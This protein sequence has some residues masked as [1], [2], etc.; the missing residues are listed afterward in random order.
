M[1]SIDEE[2]L[3][4]D[5]DDEDFLLAACGVVPSCEFK[6]DD[7]DGVT[8]KSTKDSNFQTTNTGFNRKPFSSLENS[9]SLST[10]KRTQFQSPSDFLNPSKPAG[11][12]NINISHKCINNNSNFNKMCN[13]KANQ[14]TRTGPQEQPPSKRF[15]S[16][17]NNLSFTQNNAINN[18][19]NQRTPNNC[20]NLWKMNSGEQRD[21]RSSPNQLSKYMNSPQGSN[22]QALNGNN[23]QSYSPNVSSGGKT[24]L[25]GVSQTSSLNFNTPDTSYSRESKN[26]TQRDRQ[27]MNKTGNATGFCIN[28]TPSGK[29]TS[30]KFPGP[31]GILPKLTNEQSLEEVSIKLSPL[32]STSR[33]SPVNQHPVSLQSTSED[34]E[35]TRDPWVGMFNEY[36]ENVPAT[37]RYSIIQVMSEAACQRLRYG[38]VPSLCVLVKTFSSSETDS[39]IF[40][41]DP[42]GEIHGTLHKKVLE[43]YQ[44]E[45]G[46]GAGL[47][48]KQVS[49]F[50]PS[51]RKHYLNITP[52][53]IIEIYP[54]D[55]SHINSSQLLASQG[56][57]SV[58]NN[59]QRTVIEEPEIIL[60]PLT[61]TSD[62]QQRK[63]ISPEKPENFDELLEGLDN[64]DILDEDLLAMY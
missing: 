17:S 60:E 64:D 26:M 6:P 47:I 28:I 51:P 24:S 5:L 53:N 50:S 23:M 35:F 19:Q 2:E 21:A 37:M 40:L 34:E 18:S 4:I 39:S 49:V 59:K 41:K 32:P 13:L 7:T 42:T 30:R 14:A 52:G 56:T 57:Q 45:L 33:Q 43:E 27:Q 54:P 8:S 31:A 11:S 48:L 63:E 12:A 1:F 61:N 25:N 20:N 55:P 62:K 10:E 16:N 15:A 9:T 36:Q 58:R 46:P 22:L 38:K 44:T 3:D 29:K